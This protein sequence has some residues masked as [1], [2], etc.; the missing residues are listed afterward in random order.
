MIQITEVRIHLLDR[1]DSDLK[2][3]ANITLDDC[4][5]IHGVR[6]IQGE[7]GLFVGMPR[8]KRR[9]DGSYQDVAHP[10]NN[11]TRQLIEDRVLEAYHDA[12]LQGSESSSSSPESSE[13]PPLDDSETT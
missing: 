7:R 4:F 1:D 12:K 8:R 10:I 6:I 3:Y 9:R 2:A 5:V 11:E 13:E